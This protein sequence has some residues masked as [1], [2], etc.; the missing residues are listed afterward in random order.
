MDHAPLQA[1]LALLPRWLAHPPGARALPCLWAG[2]RRRPIADHVA[3]V[4]A[5]SALWHGPMP[6][7]VGPRTLINSFIPQEASCSS[8]S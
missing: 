4:H 7:L 8:S 3:P 6:L 5:L 1:L 2:H